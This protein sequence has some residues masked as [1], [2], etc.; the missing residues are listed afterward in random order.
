MPSIQ[1]WKEI[2]CHKNYPL[3]SLFVDSFFSFIV[4][5]CNGI[6]RQRWASILCHATLSPNDDDDDDDT[7]LTGCV[8]R[9]FRIKLY[10][11]DFLGY[12]W[13]H[14]RYS[15]YINYVNARLSSSRLS[16]HARLASLVRSDVCAHTLHTDENLW[17]KCLNCVCRQSVTKKKKRNTPSN[18]PSDRCISILRCVRVLL[19]VSKWINVLLVLFI[20]YV[21]GMGRVTCTHTHIAYAGPSVES[22][23]LITFTW[24]PKM[25]V[26]LVLGEKRLAFFSLH[27][28]QSSDFLYNLIAL[29]T[30][31]RIDSIISRCCH[32]A[33]TFELQNMMIN[34]NGMPFSPRRFAWHENGSLAMTAWFLPLRRYIIL[35]LTHWVKSVFIVN[36]QQITCF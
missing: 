23:P 32:S 9:A 15:I 28:I 35:F 20:T 22:T 5:F 16:A 25:N 1:Q 12:Q 36:D 18:R 11:S 24:E 13:P 19:N 26:E 33:K 2:S 3:F 17:V 7:K 4:F 6:H 34:F 10:S 27:F 14:T 29:D 31:S 30:N 8:F 21:D